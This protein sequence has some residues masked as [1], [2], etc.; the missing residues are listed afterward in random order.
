MSTKEKK[1]VS[2][3]AEKL[4]V[5]YRDTLDTITKARYLDKLK[6]IDGKDPYEVDKGEWKKTDIE[7][8][9]DLCYPDIVNYLVC[10][11]SVYTLDQLKAYKSLQAYNYFISGFVQDLGHTV[12]NGKSVFLAKIKHSQRMNETPL[13]PWLI[14]ETDG[15]VISAHC[16]CMAGIGE[17]CS[18]VG[19]VLFAVEAA[20]KIRN[21]KT[22]T[23][24]KAY[25]LLPSSISKIG[26]C[27]LMGTAMI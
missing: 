1:I 20:V 10:S 15:S 2:L 21:T 5:L 9:P 27:Y 26:N 8:W 17:V 7:K 3:A 25:W 6:I 16:T 12:I 23:Q 19:A 24:E 18:H 22:V 13:L 11:Q 14:A 4:N